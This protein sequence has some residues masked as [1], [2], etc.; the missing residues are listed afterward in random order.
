MQLLQEEMAK[1]IFA[2]KNGN[3]SFDCKGNNTFGH[4]NMRTHFS[5]RIILLMLDL[6]VASP[7]VILCYT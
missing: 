4:L 3:T 2:T 5:D 6:I 7:H 1:H